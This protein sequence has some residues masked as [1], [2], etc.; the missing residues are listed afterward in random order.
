[1]VKEDLGA[2]TAGTG[3]AHGPEVVGRIGG[4]LVVADAHHALVG[5]PD[6]LGP[7]VV[8]LVIGGVDGDPELVLRQLQPLVAGEE[9]PGV[10]DGVALEVV[11]EA[12]VAQHLEEGVV[13]SG[14]ADVFQVVVLAAGTYAFLAGSGAGV[15]ALLQAK[16]AV[17]ELVHPRVGEQQGRVVARN[18]GAGS[19]TGMPLLFEEAQEGFTDFCAFHRFFHGNCGH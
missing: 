15:G 9:F 12:E 3:V 14:V 6:F 11:A 16:E 7:D 4:A 10:V 18:Q 2:G 13:T 19:D 17:L 8:G 5:N 1:M